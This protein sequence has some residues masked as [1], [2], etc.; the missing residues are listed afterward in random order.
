MDAGRVFG[1]GHQVAGGGEAGHLDPGLGQYRVRCDQVDPGH[2][3][4]LLRRRGDRGGLGLDP[5]VQGGDIGADRISPGQ[6]LAQQERVM[7]G[8]IAG[9]RLLQQGDLLAHAAPGQLGQHRGAALAG[10]QCGHHVPAGGPEDVADHHA[11]LD[12]G[13]LQQL[14]DPVLLRR[15]GRYQVGAVAGQVP[16]LADLGRGHEARPDHLPLGDLAQP[17]AVQLVG[18][19]AAR[20]VLDVLGVDQPRLEP[21]RLQQVEHRLPVVRRGL[22]DDPGHPQ[23]GQPVGH[24]QQRAGHRG[25]RSHLLQPPARMVLVGDPHAA[26][27]LGLADIHRRDPLDDLL[28]VFRPGQHLASSDRPGEG[29]HPQEPQA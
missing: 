25:M 9:E 24:A 17:D 10:D 5:C 20:Q 18:F 14:L 22:H 26:R 4:Q 8:E 21:G 11:Q 27:Q 28:I 6:H 3:I 2:L 15:A 12:L 7:V 23:A 16:Q 1:P 13:V 29:R 19:G